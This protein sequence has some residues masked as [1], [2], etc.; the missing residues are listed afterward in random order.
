MEKTTGGRGNEKLNDTI[1]KVG[2]LGDNAQREVVPNQAI[3]SESTPTPE[4]SSR[5]RFWRMRWFP[6]RKP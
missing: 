6:R 4:K 2:T 1:S 5:S 3:D